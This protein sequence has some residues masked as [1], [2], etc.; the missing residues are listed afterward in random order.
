[1]AKKKKKKDKNELRF[2]KNYDYTDDPTGPGKGLWNGPVGKYKSVREFIEKSR[3]RSKKNQRMK[4][5][6]ELLKKVK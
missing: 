4:A 6:A 5:Y 2:F 1:M 3:K